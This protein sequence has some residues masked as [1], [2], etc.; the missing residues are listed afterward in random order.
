[1]LKALARH[2]TA[3]TRHDLSRPIRRAIDDG[4]LELGMTVFDYG[5][6]KGSDV[7]LLRRA[8]YEAVGWDPY[9]APQESKMRANVVNLGYVVNVIE[10]AAERREAL[11]LACSLARRVLV[12]AAQTVDD[13]RGAERLSFGD[14]VVTRRDTFQKYFRQDELRRFIEETLGREPV[15]AEVGVFY[16]FIDETDHQLFLARKAARRRRMAP[17]EV[18]T[19]EQRLAPFRDLLQAFAG[20]VDELGRLPRPSEFERLNEL[21]DAIGTPKRCVR[22]CEQV[23]KGFSL[24]AARKRRA[25]DLLVYIALSRFQSRP[26]FSVLPEPLQW[27]IHDLFGSYARACELG[28]ELLFRIGQPGV[29]DAACQASP[30]GKLL[31][32][33]LYVHASAVDQL[34]SELRVYVGCGRAIV[35]EMP[36]ATVLKLKRAEPKISYL[37]YPTFDKCAHPA[38][39][40]STKVDLRRKEVFVRRYVDSENPPIL[41]RKE[42]FVDAGYPGRA[43]FAA[44]TAK[45]EAAGVFDEPGIGFE[46]QWKEILGRA[47]L[48]VRGHQLCRR[49]NSDR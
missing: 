40:T 17:R 14:G 24:D 30:V 44:L 16:V 7:R 28:D 47:G 37:A 33:A 1:M 25:D 41:H 5:C 9:Y 32:Q 39:A 36:D 19:I 42:T 49:R 2:K 45:E 23:L 11:R 15:A 8:G 35:G 20:A 13:S 29:I 48:F 21:R 31:P 3:I 22:L 34:P 26:Q 18:L 46:K 6:G 12:V 27:D 4:V 43:K 10:D 38:L